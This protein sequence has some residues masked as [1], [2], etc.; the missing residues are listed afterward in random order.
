MKKV[1]RMKTV[2]VS[3]KELLIFKRSPSKR[4]FFGIKTKRLALK[5]LM[6]EVEK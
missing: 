6:E 5:Q 3:R 2:N 1:F 4:I